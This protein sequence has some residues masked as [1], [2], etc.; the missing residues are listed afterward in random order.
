LADF[1]AI[2]VS[3]FLAKRSRLVPQWVPS[4]V[5]LASFTFA[6]S[7]QEVLAAHAEGASDNSP[8]REIA[9]VFMMSPF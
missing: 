5:V 9:F 8:N 2:P 7:A 3:P 4:M 6:R 1:T